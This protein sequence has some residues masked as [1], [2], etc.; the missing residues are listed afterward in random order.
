MA[1]LA[2]L[3][4]RGAL[5]GPKGSGKTTLLENFQ[6]AYRQQGL[7]VLTLHRR[8]GEPPLPTLPKSLDR[9]LITV[10][11]AEQLGLWE[12]LK[13]ERQSKTAVGLLVT[14]HRPLS[15]IPTLY[16]HRTDTDL[17]ISLTHELLARDQLSCPWS[18]D[19]LRRLFERH[20]GNLREAFGELFD[21]LALDDCG[22]AHHQDMG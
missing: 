4:H 3:D 17:F 15:W 14:C 11:G 7:R 16:L 12:R 2:E 1:E 22:G 13:L 10:D 8:P 18:Q 5:V 6:D 19:E 9:T 21:R 20:H